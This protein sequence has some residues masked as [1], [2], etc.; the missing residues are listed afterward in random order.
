MVGAALCFATAGIATGDGDASAVSTGSSTG[1]ST[2]STAG[3]G[4]GDGGASAVSTAGS[5]T[6][7]SKFSNAFLTSTAGGVTGCGTLTG[8]CTVDG[9]TTAKTSAIVICAAAGVAGCG[10][11]HGG[12]CTFDGPLGFSNF[13]L[14]EAATD[15]TLGQS[16]STRCVAMKCTSA[17][18]AN[19]SKE[20]SIAATENKTSMRNN[21]HSSRKYYKIATVL[22]IILM[23]QRRQSSDDPLMRQRRQSGDEPLIR[24]RR[25]SGD[26]PLYGTMLVTMTGRR[27]SAV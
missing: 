5:L 3:V 26:D 12:M 14:K 4:T 17:L 8:M 19:A 23:R 13:V 2:A 22:T 11:L 20:L 1:V 7:V 25:Q 21:T 15:L 9:P 18:L 6:G 10:K 27:R 24:Q 16:R